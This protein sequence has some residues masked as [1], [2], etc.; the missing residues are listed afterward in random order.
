[1][2]ARVQVMGILN[3]TPDSFSDGG[4]FAATGAAVRHGLELAAQGADIVDVGGESTRPGAEEVDAADEAARVVPVIRALARECGVPISVDTTKASVAEAALEAGAVIVNDVSALRSD[5]AMTA[6][7]AGSGA[8]VVL[9]HMLGTPRTMQADP[10]YGD[11]VEE[12]AGALLGWAAAAEAAGIGRERIVVDPG[13]GFGKTVAHNLSLLRRLDRL[14]DAGYPVLVGPS[15]K[16]FIGTVLGLGVEDRLEGT[17]AAVAW[18][19]AAG[20]RIVRVHDVRPMVRVV[21]LVEA[22]VSVP[23]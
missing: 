5:P 4:L 12:V 8:G 10:R 2:A 16:S 22:I 19:V 14:V 23:A 15:R 9:M 13:I 17:A 3:V 20:A 1:V 11:V 6:L 18:S 7:V 21:R